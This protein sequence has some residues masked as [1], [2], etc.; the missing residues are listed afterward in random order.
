MF[1]KTLIACVLLGLIMVQTSHG[2]Y[3]TMRE[4]TAKCFIEEVPKDTLLVASWR[5]EDMPR[6][7]YT[8]NVQQETLASKNIGLTVTVKD[9][10]D[11][12]VYT[13]NHD[14]TDKM[15]FTSATGGE[16][17]ICFVTTSSTWFHT[18][19]FLFHLQ[20]KTGSGGI[21]YEAVAKREHLDGMAIQVR[22]LNDRLSTIRSLQA[23]HKGRESKLRDTSESTYERVFYWSL[24]Q[25]LIVLATVFVQTRYLKRF[26]SQKKQH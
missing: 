3:L 25:I 18:F 16:H 22:K 12:I 26:F 24:L 19:E 11:Q 21:D 7:T 13:H 1:S 10:L 23:Y 15:A 20:I 4:G 9:P 17:L 5:S 14:K 6:T 2:M 8:A